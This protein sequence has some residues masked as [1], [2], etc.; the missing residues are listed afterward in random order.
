[1][2][3]KAPAPT[4]TAKPA[5]GETTENLFVDFDRPSASRPSAVNPLTEHVK[6]LVA[7]RDDEG[8]SRGSKGIRLAGNTEEEI[9]V[10]AKR[11]RRH[12]VDAGKA[13]GVTVRQQIKE[14]EGAA[15]GQFWVV[16]RISR[17]RT[18]TAEGAPK[19]E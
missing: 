10:S 5:P 17:P 16:P 12:C 15:F 2:A 9:A 3:T 1:M 8:I 18:A 11:F 19:P 7:D 13:H 4:A 6:A 14:H